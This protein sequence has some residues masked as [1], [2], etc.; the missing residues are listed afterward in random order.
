LGCHTH[1]VQSQ[2][3]SHAAGAQAGSHAAGAQA[4]SQGTGVQTFTGTCL[5]TTRGTQRVTV[6]GT[7]LQIVWKVLMVLVYCTGFMTV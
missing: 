1:D 3:G 4:G 6:Y 5:H 2:A 7:F